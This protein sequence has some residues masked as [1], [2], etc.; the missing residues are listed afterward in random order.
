MDSWITLH[1]CLG[2][3]LDSCTWA[4]DFCSYYSFLLLKSS[5]LVFL[6]S[7]ILIASLASTKWSNS[8]VRS[9]FY[10]AN[11]LIWLFRASISDYRFELLSR[12]AEFEYL[13][14]SSSFLCAIIVSSRTLIF[15]SRSLIETERSKFFP[16]S[17]SILLYKSAFSNL[18]LS[19]S[20]LR[21]SSSF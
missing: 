8:F 18:Y 15:D 19:S 6:S 13:A 5:T 4:N 12:R 20:D 11:T 21:C 7:L 17:E 16:P 10:D 14:P 1:L 9:S 3:D 2:G